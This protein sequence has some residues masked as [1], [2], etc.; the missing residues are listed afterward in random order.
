MI[1]ERPQRLL[2]V[3]AG[4]GK[5][6]VLAREY[7]E[8]ATVDAIDANPPRYPVYDRTFIGDI[9]EL[10]RVL[11]VDAEPYDLALLIDVI[12]H[13]TK[14]EGWRLLDDLT[15]RAKRILLTTPLG[16]R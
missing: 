2:D 5:F 6:G 7:A 4:W 3:G 15:V 1:R 12:E 8:P 11:P 14:E 9:R 10:G 16:F 13:L